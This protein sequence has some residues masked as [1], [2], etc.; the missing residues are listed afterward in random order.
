MP[1]QEQKVTPETPETSETIENPETLETPEDIQSEELTEEETKISFLSKQELDNLTK[2][3]LLEQAAKVG[4]SVPSNLKKRKA[5]I[6]EFL[7]DK[8]PA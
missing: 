5:N 4:I 8:I 3:Q 6:V 7:I 2:Q 1:V